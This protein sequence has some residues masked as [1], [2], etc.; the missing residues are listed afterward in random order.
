MTAKI[1]IKSYV[2]LD[3]D[4]GTDEICFETF[5]SN[6][7]SCAN[8]LIET[9]PNLTT[10]HFGVHINITFSVLD[11]V[12]TLN[13]LLN[14]FINEFLKPLDKGNSQLKICLYL[15]W[16]INCEQTIYEV[17]TYIIYGIS[18]IVISSGLST[19]VGLGFGWPDL[20]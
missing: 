13:A 11:H 9:C 14:G 19:L 8:F 6:A 10:L 1:T 15:T 4:A 17:C 2:D 18:R 3:L 5:V 16:E 12:D 7:K 20:F